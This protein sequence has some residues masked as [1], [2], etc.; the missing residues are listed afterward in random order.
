[1]LFDCLTTSE[2]QA[3]FYAD[4]LLSRAPP[5]TQNAVLH[6]QSRQDIRSP[7]I[8]LAPISPAKRMMVGKV[9]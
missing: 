6:D 3:L 8:P 5:I 4:Q 1:M 2:L 7:G 9:F